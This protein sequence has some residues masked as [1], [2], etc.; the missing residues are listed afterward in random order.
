MKKEGGSEIVT[1]FL[2]WQQGDPVLV[3]KLFDKNGIKRQVKDRIFNWQSRGDV[4]GSF[5]ELAFTE[6]FAK[7]IFVFKK[8]RD[9]SISATRT[10]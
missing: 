3:L 2:D 5:V 10:T 6:E 4:P 1:P 9:W 7:A 8:N